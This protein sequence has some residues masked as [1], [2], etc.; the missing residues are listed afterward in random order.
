MTLK[1]H[2]CTN[3]NGTFRTSENAPS[4][5]PDGVC[6]KPQVR[7]IPNLVR[8]RRSRITQWTQRTHA[9]ISSFALHV[10]TLRSSVFTR[11][12]I[13]G[14]D[15]MTFWRTATAL[16]TQP[17]LP[18]V[19]RATRQLRTIPKLVR[20]RR[21]RISRWTLTMPI[22]RWTGATLHSHAGGFLCRLRVHVPATLPLP[23]PPAWFLLPSAPL[24]RSMHLHAVPAQQRYQ[25]CALLVRIPSS[26]SGG[27]PLA[28]AGSCSSGSRFRLYNTS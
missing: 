22:L 15:D 11:T 7:A 5:A 14:Q 2:H 8:L 24:L 9:V 10:P 16:S 13:R 3:D 1:I 21:P 27:N 20:L 6:E 4:P 28:Q 19:A 26:R 17:P 23:L 25:R 12:H 18:A